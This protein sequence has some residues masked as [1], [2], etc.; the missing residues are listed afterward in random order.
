ML[1][2]PLEQVSHNRS[3]LSS[4]IGRALPL[5]AYCIQG[6][7]VAPSVDEGKSEPDCRRGDKREVTL[8]AADFGFD[9]SVSGEAAST[10]TNLVRGF[11]ANRGSGRAA[12]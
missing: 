9:P 6:A 11:R 3:L 4:A 2:A 5:D 1:V 12:K 8:S 7:V 10:P